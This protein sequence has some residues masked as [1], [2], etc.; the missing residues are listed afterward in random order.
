[1]ATERPHF[2]ERIAS[3]P[4]V[5]LGKPVVR[6]TRIPVE[7]ILDQLSFKPDLGEL[8]AISPELTVED[9]RACLA[10]A[11]PAVSRG[12]RVGPGARLC[13]WA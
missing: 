4:E 5:M 2:Q 11:S 10:F 3:D 7:R 9:V 1:M 8:F 12:W 13:P 6:G